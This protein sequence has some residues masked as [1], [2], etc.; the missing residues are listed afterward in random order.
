[1]E[2]RDNI[3]KNIGVNRNENVLVLERMDL[4]KNEILSTQIG[5]RTYDFSGYDFKTK[6][7]ISLDKLK[8]KYVLLDFMATWCGPCIKE[9]PN[10]KTLYENIDKSKF[11]IISIIGDSPLDALEKMIEKHGIAWSQIVS[12]DTNKIKESYGIKGY[13]TTFLLNPEGF[14]IAKNLRG[15]ELE[16]KIIKEISS[17]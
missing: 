8:G 13:P 15:K 14:I 10:L 17:Q 11:E 1:M 2:I 6:K 12:D 5:F 4:P 16:N 3:Y 7:T 9:I